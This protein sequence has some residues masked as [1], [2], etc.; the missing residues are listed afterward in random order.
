MQQRLNTLEVVTSRWRSNFCIQGQE[1]LLSAYLTL[2]QPLELQTGSKSKS[3]SIPSPFLIFAPPVLTNVPT[4]DHGLL[5]SDPETAP[6]LDY[7]FL[8]GFQTV[9]GRE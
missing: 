9:E 6:Q 5:I 4:R 3:H 2:G 7:R 1:P 8:V